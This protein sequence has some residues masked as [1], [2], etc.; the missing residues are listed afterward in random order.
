MISLL[1]QR[2]KSAL[3]RMESV[4]LLMCS[5]KSC[6]GFT[7]IELIVVMI[8]ISILS[9]IALPVF[10]RQIGKARE[11]EVQLKLGAIARSQTAYHYT[12]SVFAQTMAIL[13]ADTGQINSFYY[14][15]PDPTTDGQNIKHQAIAITP[16]SY[17]TRDYAIGVYYVN[18]GYE[19]ATCQ[20]FDIS[21]SV[22]VGVLSTD[23]CTNN[24]I[25]IN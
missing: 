12:N 6:G 23:S 7:L 16:G 5:E 17:Q 24:G 3:S 18:G 21:Q 11:A 1:P 20:G 4:L 15:F 9:A 2:K 19:R 13:A 22:N 10:Q 8:I 25:K 14:T